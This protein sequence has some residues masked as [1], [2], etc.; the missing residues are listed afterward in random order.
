[1]YATKFD[2]NPAAAST[3]VNKFL[4][5]ESQRICKANKPRIEVRED[6][7]IVHVFQSKINYA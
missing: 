1:M 5:A 4:L 7:A 2:I 6:G 3:Q